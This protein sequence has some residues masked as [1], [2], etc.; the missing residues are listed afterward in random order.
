MGKKTYLI[1]ITKW[2]KTMYHQPNVGGGG[3]LA[4]VHVQ[5]TLDSMLNTEVTVDFIR[6]LRKILGQYRKTIA[7]A[8]FPDLHS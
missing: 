6:S 8:S 7:N 2:F 3:G 1:M 4:F 5:K